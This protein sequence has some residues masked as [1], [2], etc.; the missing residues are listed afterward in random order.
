MLRVNL[1]HPKVVERAFSP[2][3]TFLARNAN[4][5]DLARF[6]LGYSVRFCELTVDF[7]QYMGKPHPDTTR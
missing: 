4:R 2:P 7:L 3:E 5:A 1:A 6:F